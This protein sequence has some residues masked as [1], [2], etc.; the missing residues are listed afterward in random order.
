MKEDKEE[1]IVDEQTI[2][3]YFS[4]RKKYSNYYKALDLYYHMS[5]HFDGYFMHIASRDEQMAFQYNQKDEMSGNPYFTR[6][7]DMRRPSESDTIKIYRRDIYLPETMSP[8][9]KVYN[10]LRKI[11]KAPDWK[12]DYSKALKPAKIANG[13]YLEDYCEFDYPEFNSV[14]NWFYTYGMRKM[15]M[16]ANALVYVLPI[17]FDVQPNEYFRPIA[18][19]VNCK[20]LYDYKENEYAIFKLDCEWKYK[21]GK[22]LERKGTVLGIITKEGYWEARQR[23]V[24][25]EFDL[26][27]VMKYETPM[28]YLPAFLTGGVVKN[29]SKDKTLYNSFLSPMLPGLDGMARA[30]SDEDAEWVQH[31]FSTMWYFSSQDCR[32]CMGTGYVNGKGKNPITC[33]QCNGT[34]G[35]PKSPYRDIVLKTGTFDSDKQ[36]TPPAGYVQKD[37]KIAEIFVDRIKNKKFEALASVSMEFLSDIPLNTS[38]TSK[39]YDRQELD[40]FTY[41]VAYHSVENVIKNIYYF[42]N[43]FRYSK[44]IPN[45]DEREK[46]LPIIPVPA[47]YDLLNS[48]AIISQLDSAKK[49]GLDPEIID[50]YEMEL[51]AKEFPDDT[52]LRDKMMLKKTLDPFPRLDVKDLN[53][54]LLGG[55]VEKRDVIVSNYL[56]SFIEQA[57]FEH[58]D[59]IDLPFDKQKEIIYAYADEKMLKMDSAQKI[60]DENSIKKLKLLNQNQPNPT[61]VK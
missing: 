3:P 35:A 17:D 16:D 7:I 47:N 42:I 39:A 37:T 52:D 6:L 4:G 50:K 1:F 59:F 29:Y 54:L 5:F 48:G 21:D 20:N 40:N 22:N 56:H 18:Q 55:S 45:A 2:K 46:M 9:F 14:E 33:S 15:L 10:A 58:K 53:D 44:V 24:K 19:V 26:V 41:S 32:A 30:I 61:N 11:V 34:G 57:L 13:E 38:G 60:K 27:E 49:A 12:I 23:N 36:P 8:C 43:E 31:V 25:G 28:E 51:L